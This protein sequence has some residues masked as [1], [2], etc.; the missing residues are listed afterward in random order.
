MVRNNGGTSPS[1]SDSTELLRVAPPARCLINYALETS[2]ELVENLTTNLEGI[3][4]CHLHDKVV[5][6]DII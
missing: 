3:E 5:N 4:I 6:I 2:T 1:S